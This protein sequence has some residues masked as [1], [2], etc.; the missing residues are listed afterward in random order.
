MIKPQV[1]YVCVFLPPSLPFL[2]IQGKPVEDMLAKLSLKSG[3][4]GGA[5]AAK[6]SADA[7]AEGEEGAAEGGEVSLFDWEDGVLISLANMSHFHS[8]LYHLSS[9]TGRGG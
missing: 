5:A 7:P 3:G 9:Q 1:T 2:S 4:G 6:P 8:F